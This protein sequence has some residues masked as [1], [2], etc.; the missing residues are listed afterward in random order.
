MGKIKIEIT[1]L[2]LKNI[3]HALNYVYSNHCGYYVDDMKSR[4]RAKRTYY[5]LLEQEKIIKTKEGNK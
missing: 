5:K 2:D 3:Y 4:T 1:D